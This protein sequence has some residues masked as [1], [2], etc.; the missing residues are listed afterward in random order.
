MTKVI[1]KANTNGEPERT[2]L[3][4]DAQILA[5]VND[6]VDFPDYTI[7]EPD[8]LCYHKGDNVYVV[9]NDGEYLMYEGIRY[10]L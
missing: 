10:D 1:S 6:M 3:L 8:Q 5:I 7:G 9:R 4:S 2:P